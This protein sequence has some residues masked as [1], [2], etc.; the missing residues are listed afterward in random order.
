MNFLPAAFH[1][2]NRTC[3]SK[4]INK[5]CG[6]LLLKTTSWRTFTSSYC[7]RFQLFF[8]K[9]RWICLLVRNVSI[10]CLQQG[11]NPSILTASAKCWPWTEAFKILKISNSPAGKPWRGP[12][13]NTSEYSVSFQHNVEWQGMLNDLIPPKSTCWPCNSLIKRTPNLRKKKWPRH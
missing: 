1:C 5:Q 10:E 3:F 12:F 11:T 4:V 2:S 9:C 13:L 7:V 8:F 6:S